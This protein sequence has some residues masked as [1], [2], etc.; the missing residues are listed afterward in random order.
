MI[1]VTKKLVESE[2]NL[3]GI[4]TDVLVSDSFEFDFLLKIATIGS[5]ICIHVCTHGRFDGLKK[6][7]QAFH[8]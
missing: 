6:R 1:E 5:T 3:D 8:K 4:K 2:D 7:R